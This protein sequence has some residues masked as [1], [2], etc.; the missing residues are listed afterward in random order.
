[1]SQAYS[2]QTQLI[3]ALRK[4]LLFMYVRCTRQ[5]QCLEPSAKNASLFQHNKLPESYDCIVLQEKLRTVVQSCYMEILFFFSFCEEKCQKKQI[6]DDMHCAFSA[7]CSTL[8]VCNRFPVTRGQLWVN[9][10]SS[11]NIRRSLPNQSQCLC[12]VL[13]SGLSLLRCENFKVFSF[14]SDSTLWFNTTMVFRPTSTS[15]INCGHL[16][17]SI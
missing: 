9:T 3:P 17:I 7:Q 16:A 10:N 4:A 1:M 11:I 2:L 14:C 5:T 12:W 13:L 8:Y 15:F 6:T